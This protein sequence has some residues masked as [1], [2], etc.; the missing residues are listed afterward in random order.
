MALPLLAPA[1]LSSGVGTLR[2]GRVTVPQC[3][4]RPPRPGLAALSVSPDYLCPS[5][6]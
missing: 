3:V 2:E 6:G 1:H 4:P 5:R